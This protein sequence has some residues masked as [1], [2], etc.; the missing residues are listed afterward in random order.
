MR[1]F[2][3]RLVKNLVFVYY[4][5]RYESR[6]ALNLREPPYLPAHSQPLISAHFYFFTFLF[7]S[8]LMLQFSSKALARRIEVVE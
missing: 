8:G 1:A 6:R 7:P 3:I 5:A 4:N 2:I